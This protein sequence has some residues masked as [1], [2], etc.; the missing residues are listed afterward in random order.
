MANI[1]NNSM[2]ITGDKEQLKQLRDIIVAQDREV[3]EKLFWWFTAGD[4]YGLVGDATDIEDSNEDY[5]GLDFTSKWSPPENDLKSLSAAYPLLR[6]EVKYEEGGN[7]CYGKLVY[8][9]GVCIE[10][11][12]QTYEQWLEENDE[13]YC[14]MTEDIKTRDY[15]EVLSDFI[16]W[17][18]S[19]ETDENTQRFPDIIERKILERIEDKDLPLLVGHEWYDHTNAQEFEGRLKGKPN[20]KET[21]NKD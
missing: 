6:I 20:E 14:E 18:D 16:P 1:C 21:L 5:L 17:L 15:A 7:A 11:T 12:P 8:L 4:Y 10:D 3:L 9:G 19:L 13:V 2:E